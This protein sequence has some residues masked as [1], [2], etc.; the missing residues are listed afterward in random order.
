MDR[1]QTMEG[2]ERKLGGRNIWTDHTM[3][4]VQ[5]GKTLPKD[6]VFNVVRKASSP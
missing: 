4:K 2:Q 1:R 6:L 3:D 5:P